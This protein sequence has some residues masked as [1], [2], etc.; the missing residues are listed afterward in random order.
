MEASKKRILLLYHF[1]LLSEMRVGV[2][3]HLHTLDHSDV[4]HD[5]LYYNTVHGAPS[6]LRHLRFDAV[7]LHNTLLCMRWSPIFYSWKWNLRWIKDLEC[8]KIA[9]PQDEYDHAEILDEWL[10]EW[11]ISVIFTNF[12]ESY[13]R[14]LYPLLHD[15]AGF[16]KSF[17]GYIDDTVAQD[18]SQTLLPMKERPND[19]VYRAFNLP[20]WFGSHGQL[21]HII[22]GVVRKHAQ[23][24]GL[25][26]DISTRLED[27]IIGPHWI[28]FLASGKVVIGC[29]SGSSVLDRRGEI[30]AQIKAILRQT[31]EI[32]FE[33]LS[34]RMPEGWDDYRFFAISPRHFEAIIT[35]TCQILVEG[36]YDGI[37]E[38]DKHYIPLKKDFSNI[39]EVL[40]K[41]KDVQYLT[42]I[43]ERAYQD[44]YISGKYTYRK[45]A[46]NIEGVLYKQPNKYQWST[47]KKIVAR[48]GLFGGHLSNHL[49][50]RIAIW[51]YHFWRLIRNLIIGFRS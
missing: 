24:S 46:E 32:S 8:L 16:Y 7:I 26:C 14:D 4:D 44:I 30:Q 1:P 27:T 41:V 9:I 2:L 40:E 3:H 36:Y 29:E 25:K 33:E 39:D 47:S 23:L 49:S 15:N 42:D 5:I 43:A 10:Y 21:K 51:E 13:R 22:A 50:T 18:Y 28:D 12:D 31:S 35:K 48:L 37:L 19:I 17:T 6:W 38:R 11:G 34:Q 20:F 45:F